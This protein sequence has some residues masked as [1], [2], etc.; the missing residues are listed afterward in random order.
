MNGRSLTEDCEKLAADHGLEVADNHH[1]DDNSR[2][3]FNGKHRPDFE[4]MLTAALAGEFHTVLVWDDD[5]L[6]RDIWTTPAWC[7]RS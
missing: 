4:K 5:R 7:G 3:A 2:S 6:H 1:Y